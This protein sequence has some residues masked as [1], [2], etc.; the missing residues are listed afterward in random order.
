M[1]GKPA[2]LIYVVIKPKWFSLKTVTVKVDSHIL[3][4]LNLK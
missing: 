3:G 2:D 1:S 4:N